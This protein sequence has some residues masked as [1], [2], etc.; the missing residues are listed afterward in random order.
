M[1][2]WTPWQWP[3]TFSFRAVDWIPPWAEQ[4]R[5]ERAKT[6]DDRTFLHATH[7]RLTHSPQ[8]YYNNSFPAHVTTTKI[9]T[10]LF[11]ELHESILSNT[12][13]QIIFQ[14]TDLFSNHRVIDLVANGGGR[15]VGLCR[16]SRWGKGVMLMSQGSWGG[17]ERADQYSAAVPCQLAQC[18]RTCSRHCQVLS[19]PYDC[20]TYTE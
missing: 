16:T 5:S 13:I 2:V 17:R 3:L 12:K 11:T 8:H 6:W 7:S 19:Q 14:L 15:D 20:H 18:Q 9:W 10:H 1:V 4:S